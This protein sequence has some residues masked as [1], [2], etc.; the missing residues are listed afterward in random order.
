MK[1][2]IF[3]VCTITLLLI[4]IL[5]NSSSNI[6]AAINTNYDVGTAV[7]ES[8]LEKK[9]ND[10]IILD[11][12]GSF[13]YA[14][15]SLVEYIVGKAFQGITGINTF[16]WADKVIFNSVPMLDVN[17]FNPASGSMFKSTGGTSTA[18]SDIVRST[19]FTILA[20]A[21]GFLVVVVGISAIKLALSSL[22]SEKAKYKEAL[23]KW[24]FSIV[25]LFLM[26][27]LMSFIFF[28]MLFCTIVTYFPAIVK[29]AEF[30]FIS[31]SLS[32]S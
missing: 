14:T 6:F 13:I 22:A 18:L 21:I 20:I 7:E 23:S 30:I 4:I 15:A 32:A 29:Y 8:N 2:K 12:L 17:F 25:M 19:Y 28:V 5:F 1:N 16:P 11:A 9:V 31:A 10:S 26:H 24:L 27:N 3:K